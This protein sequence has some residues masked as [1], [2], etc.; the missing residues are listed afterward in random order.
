MLCQDMIFFAK[1]CVMG[2]LTSEIVHFKLHHESKQNKALL[3]YLDM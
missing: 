1:N 3:S 2:I